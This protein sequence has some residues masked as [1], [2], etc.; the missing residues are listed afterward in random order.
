MFVNGQ[1]FHTDIGSFQHSTQYSACDKN[2]N[3]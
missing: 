1:L 3:V 2:D